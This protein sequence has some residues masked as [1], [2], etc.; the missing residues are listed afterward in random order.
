MLSPCCYVARM[1]SRD[2]CD[3]SI[4]I[5]RSERLSQSAS[6]FCL[7][8]NVLNERNSLYIKERLRLCR[9]HLQ[10][11]ISVLCFC[12]VRVANFMSNWSEPKNL[13]LRRG[14]Q[15]RVKY[16]NK[17]LQRLRLHGQ[18]FSTPPNY[19]MTIQIRKLPVKVKKY[20]WDLRA[21][22]KK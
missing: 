12:Y 22:V 20:N 5:G 1:T 15:R 18:I 2:M 10:Q 16:L 4:S 9:S 21:D 14:S 7:C 19:I 8:Q 17:M 13:E 3:I 11:L 6:T